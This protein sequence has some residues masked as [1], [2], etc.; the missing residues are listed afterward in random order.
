VSRAELRSVGSRRARTG[1]IAGWLAGASDT[2]V[3]LAGAHVALD[4]FPKVKSLLDEIRTRLL[5]RMIEVM[6]VEKPMAKTRTRA[7]FC[8]RGY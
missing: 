1:C 2:D 3:G 4:A 5:K 6:L 7:V 8:F